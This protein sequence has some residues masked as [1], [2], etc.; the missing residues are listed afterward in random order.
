MTEFYNKKNNQQTPH[1]MYTK[2]INVDYQGFF[3]QAIHDL[4]EWYIIN[5]RELD[6]DDYQ[7]V[8]VDDVNYF[9]EWLTNNQ[10]FYAI[11]QYLPHDNSKLKSV[12]EDCIDTIDN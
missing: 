10:N 3:K 12:I 4:W 6:M 11:N 2:T 1:Q 7:N 5:I 9:R 8:D